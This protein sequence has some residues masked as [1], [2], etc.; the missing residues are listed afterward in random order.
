MD[1][2]LISDSYRE[3]NR[4]LHEQNPHYGVTGGVRARAVRSL[5]AK[6]GAEKVL[7]YG[8]GKGYLKIALG[9]P[10][11]LREY[12]PAITGKDA[13]PEPA[14]LVVCSD[15][16]EHIEP[17]YLD[18][19]LAHLS[20]LTRKAAY[21]VVHTGPAA[22]K[23]PDG[24]NAHLIQRPAQ[25]WEGEINRFMRARLVCADEIEAHF[26]CEQ[27]NGGQMADLPNSQQVES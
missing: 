21:L 8:C 23:L 25:W 18:A 4:L 16:L 19:V 12:D 24:R 1:Q 2:N 11:W 6:I 13:E 9:S 3:Q 27:S 22:K 7:D 17:E 14:D 5:V 26:I 20:A 10:E 15:V